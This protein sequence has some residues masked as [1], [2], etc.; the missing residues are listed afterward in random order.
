MLSVI[1]N[2]AR[3]R[4][5]GFNLAIDDFGTAYSS[6]FQLSRIPF[7]ELKIERAFVRAVDE[8]SGKQ[9]IVRAC[10]QLGNSMGLHVVA[11]GVETAQE[12]D[13]VQQAGCTQIQGYLVA[14]PMPAARALDWL[15]GL[16]E[17]RFDLP[18]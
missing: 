12:L 3:I 10:S 8:D 13:F 9:A 4:M 1:E 6:L 7:S 11:E 2:A 18:N 16:D 14:R 5:L 17:L 15:R